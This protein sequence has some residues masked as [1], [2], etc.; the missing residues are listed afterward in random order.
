MRHGDIPANLGAM[1]LLL[2]RLLGANFNITT[3]QAITI[4]ASRYVPRRIIATNVS[5]SL[6]LAVGG[7]YTRQNKTGTIIV[8]A[9]QVYSALTNSSKFLDLTLAAL[10]GTDVLTAATL[11]FSLTTAQGAPATGDLYVIGDAL[12]TS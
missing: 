2:G 11:Y 4:D 10:L 7:I 3:D 6:T 8:A 1:G 5:T 12:P 9:A